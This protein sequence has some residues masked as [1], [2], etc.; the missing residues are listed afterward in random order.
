MKRNGWARLL[1]IGM[2][3]FG[4]Q[5]GAAWAEGDPAAGQTV[6]KKCA[7]CHTVE[8]GGPNKVGPNLHG[9]FG[10]QSGSLAG[11]KYSTAMRDAAIIWSA[12]TLAEYLADPKAYVPGNKMPF[13]GLKNVK[14][15][16][17]VIAYLREA[18]Q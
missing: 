7:V 15:R 4:L 8:A 11:F 16:D 17:D 14:D 12:E 2:L 10:R 3:G 5:I 18:T 9:L 1:A 6:F 13:P